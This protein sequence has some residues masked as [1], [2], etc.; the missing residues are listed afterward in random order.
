LQ[1]EAEALF[2]NDAKTDR[3]PPPF[4]AAMG[5]VRLRIQSAWGLF[6]PREIDAGTRLLLRFLEPRPTD[7][8]LDLGCG[9]GPIGLYMATLAPEGQT[10][11][12]D[13]DFVAVET[14]KRNADANGLNNVSTLL[15]DGFSAL[16][17]QSFDKIATNLPAKVGREMLGFFIEDAR[18]HLRPDGEL[19]VVIISSL[20]P[21]V[22][23]EMLQVFGNAVK[24]K[25][26]PRHSVLR[27]RLD[28]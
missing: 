2:M 22:K 16:S 21:L 26:G 6:S 18:A 23:R 9:Y 27:C 1:D 19:W 28:E 25:Q 15:S 5:S 8:C 17:G 3:E 4:E 20:R 24:V 11:M 12:V 14:A 13:R 7:D 10:L